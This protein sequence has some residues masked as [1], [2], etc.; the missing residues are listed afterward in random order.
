MLSAKVYTFEDMLK[1]K[2]YLVYTNVGMSMMPFLRECRDIIEIRPLTNRAKKYDVVL[3]KV[4]HMYILHRIL[5]VRPNDY[6]ICGDHNI[7][8]EYGITD[9]MIIGVMVRAIRNGNSIYPTNLKYK[10]YVHL[11]CDLF[12]A[13]A[14]ILYI[15]R[16]IVSVYRKLKRIPARRKRV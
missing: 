15:K 4:N 5:K 6:I 9:N 12:P 16:H 7:V 1:E 2:G 13:R 8:R 14:V 3:Y 10:C 11:W